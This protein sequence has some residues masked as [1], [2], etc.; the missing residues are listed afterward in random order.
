RRIESEVIAEITQQ[1]DAIIA[2]GGGAVLREENVARLRHHGFLILLEADADTIHKRLT[3]D[4]KTE[5]QRPSLTGK[6]PQEEVRALLAARKPFYDRACDMRI[7]TAVLT[8]EQV[9]D[10]IASYM[11]P[12]G[13]ETH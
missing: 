4:Q 11:R 10:K 6:P 13:D 2:A 5:S 7:N 1:D 8:V 9:V 3:A 12:P